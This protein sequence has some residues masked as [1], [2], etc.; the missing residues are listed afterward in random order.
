MIYKVS[1]ETRAG[2][3]KSMTLLL[4]CAAQAAS[5]A[6]RAEEQLFSSNALPGI[7]SREIQRQL[8][9]WDVFISH[10]G[11]DKS[12][13]LCLHRLLE[14]TGLRSFLDDK[15]LPV[16][17]D[18]SAAMEAAAKSSQLAV[19]LLSEEFFKKSWPQQEL[20]WFL[21][22]HQATRITV[23]PVFLRITVERCE[24]QL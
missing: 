22:S 23:V 13:G 11:E 16:G 6:E 12:F 24:A 3:Y 5:A 1:K 18:A 21:E 9:K 8:W 7:A 2:A 15:S 17:G 19:V 4:R 10:A 20:H 14:Q